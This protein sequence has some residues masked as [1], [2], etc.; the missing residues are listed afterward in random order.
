MKNFDFN[1]A[2]DLKQNWHKIIR[3]LIYSIVVFILIYLIKKESENNETPD[4]GQI[5]V[6]DV[7]K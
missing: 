1:A 6:F 4:N 2:R 7:E 3:L 5:E